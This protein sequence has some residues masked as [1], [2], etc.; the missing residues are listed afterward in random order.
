MWGQ[1]AGDSFFMTPNIGN[2]L[3]LPPCVAQKSCLV[4]PV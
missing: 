2:F 4:L 1:Q 3:S